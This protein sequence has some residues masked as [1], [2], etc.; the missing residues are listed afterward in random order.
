MEQVGARKRVETLQAA[1]QLLDA[2]ADGHGA[3]NQTGFCGYRFGLEHQRADRLV[4]GF[5]QFLL[6]H[7]SVETTERYLG[8]K[9]RLHR[10]VND[11]IGLDS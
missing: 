3:P 9:Q 2:A 1:V 4:A 10:A 7:T 5:L 6:G 11:N 8:C